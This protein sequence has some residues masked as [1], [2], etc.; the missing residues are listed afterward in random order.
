MDETPV[1]EEEDIKGAIVDFYNNLYQ[2]DVKWRPR[3]EG[4]HFSLL[5]S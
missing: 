5:E 4:L 2:E 1:M 3:M